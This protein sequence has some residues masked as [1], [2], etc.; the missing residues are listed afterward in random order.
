MPAATAA[1]AIPEALEFK[2]ENR[3]AILLNTFT[4][5]IYFSFLATRPSMLLPK[6]GGAERVCKEEVG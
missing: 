5:L 1:T 2:A 4:M 6:E 3:T